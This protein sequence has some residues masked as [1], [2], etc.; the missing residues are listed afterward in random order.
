MSSQSSTEIVIFMIPGLKFR[1]KCGTKCDINLFKKK[2]QSSTEIVIFMIPGLKFWLKCGTKCDITG[3]SQVS[4][5]V[6]I[7]QI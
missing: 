7:L 5:K 2:S 1:L 6:D 4:Y 3:G